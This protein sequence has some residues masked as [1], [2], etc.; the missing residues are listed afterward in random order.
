MALRSERIAIVRKRFDAK[1]YMY[2]E[3][4]PRWM[5]STRHYLESLLARG[6]MTIR[7]IRLWRE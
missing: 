3:L 2:E 1:R 6:I 4:M 7:M 5:Q